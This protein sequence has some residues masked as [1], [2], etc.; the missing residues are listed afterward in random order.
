M[1]VGVALIGATL[2][3]LLACSD[4]AVPNYQSPSV[5]PTTPQGIQ[6]LVTGAF[7]GT[8]GSPSE[9]V[10]DVFAY[11]VLMSSFGR[12]AG[13]FTNT[14]SRYLTEWL[15]DGVPIPNSD[16]YGTVVWDN[17]F[18]TIKNAHVV[19]N[20]LLGCRA[21]VHHR[22]AGPDRRRHADVAGVQLHDAGRDA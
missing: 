7:S 21:G 10:S 20:E 13:N 8:R 14:D 1:A 6:Q 18:R 22:A 3:A 19:I 5:D 9:V 16:Y 11:V 4:P 15:G 12:D 2:T 17:E